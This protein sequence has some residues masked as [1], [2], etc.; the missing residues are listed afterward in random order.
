MVADD[1]RTDNT[2][3]APLLTQPAYTNGGTL[4]WRV[5]AIDA[6]RNQGDSSP[7]QKIGFAKQMRVSLTRFPVRGRKSAVV[8]KV[9]DS[10]NKP[11][12][13]AAVRVAGKGLKVGA[14]RTTR[15]GTATFKLRGRKGLSIVFRAV[16][17]G[18]DPA[19]YTYKVR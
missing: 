16:K 10:A 4:Y 7:A 13:G 18:F 8:V 2:S 19:T 17:T 14:R 6:D 9:V 11:V 1:M 3:Y 12:A 15:A 5:A